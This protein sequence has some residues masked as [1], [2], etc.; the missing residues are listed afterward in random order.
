MKSFLD[1]H[2]A[3]ISGV[4]SCFDRMLFRGYLPIMSGYSMAQ[5]LC[6]EKILYKDLK[7]FLLS[8][9]A[10]LKDHA[11]DMARKAERPYTYL[12]SSGV[13]KEERARAIATED[14][15]KEGLVCIFSQLEPCSTFSFRYE[16]GQAFVKPARRKCLHIYYYFMDPKFGLIHVMV[17]T[18]F[19]MRMQVFV[20]GHHW[21]ANKMTEHGIGYTQCDNTFLK[22]EDIERAQRFAD[23]L[24]SVNWPGLLN[25]Y[26]RLIN[27]HMGKLLGRM[28]D[29]WVAAQCEWAADGMF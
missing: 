22:I 13:R 29:D 11:V 12:A 16:R 15:I 20:N 25:R 10:V 17:Q 9:A 27:Q 19:P 8:N 21:L 1:K 6:Q 2:A 4:I 7:S 18:W 14:G 3:K 24:E 26:A 23:R 5:F 28:E